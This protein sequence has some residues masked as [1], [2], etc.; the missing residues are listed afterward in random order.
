LAIGRVGDRQWRAVGGGQVNHD[1][2]ARKR[3]I[4]IPV[5]VIA[6]EERE[7]LSTPKEVVIR[8]QFHRE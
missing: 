4:H 8:G 7:N 6:A 3:S 1:G 5:E 2:G